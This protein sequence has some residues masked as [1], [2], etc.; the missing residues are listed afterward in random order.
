MISQPLLL[1][2]FK[3]IEVVRWSWLA[4]LDVDEYHLQY[5]VSSSAKIYH[6]R[7]PVAQSSI[8]CQEDIIPVT[9]LPGSMDYTSRMS[10]TNVPANS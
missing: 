9:R 3:L 7:V 8:S 5:N 6:D 10:T 1:D 4:S 2:G